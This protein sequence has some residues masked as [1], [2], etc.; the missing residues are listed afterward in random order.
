MATQLYAAQHD[1]EHLSDL[2]QTELH[3]CVDCQLID[4]HSDQI[5]YSHPLS[6]DHNPT[7][8]VTITVTSAIQVPVRL[9]RSRAPPATS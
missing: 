9:T 1:I 4:N 8:V 5:L 7:A 3:Q 6:Y 2:S